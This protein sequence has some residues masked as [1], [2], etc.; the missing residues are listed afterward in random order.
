ML[1]MFT[2]VTALA[3][4]A[5]AAQADVGGTL[6]LY[7]SQPS[8]DAQKTVNAFEAAFPQVKV[9]W[10]R[11][12]TTQMMAKIEAEFAAGDPQPD[13]LLIA[14]MV[15]MERLKEDGRLMA[16]PEAN[17][18]RFDPALMD[19]DHMFFSTKLITTGIVYNTHAKMKPT[20]YTDLL[21][22]EAKGEIAMPSPLNS[23]AAAIQLDAITAN[24]ALGWD[25]YK[26]LADQGAV[27]QG[28][29]G[30]VYK[31]VASGEKL[32]GFVVDYL[33]VRGKAK[34][35]PVAFVAPKEGLT[36]VTEPVAILKTAKNVPAAK[37][38]VSFLLSAK[39]QKLAADMGYI[40]ADPAVAEPAGFPPRDQ[41]KLMAFDPAKALKDNAANLK[42]FADISGG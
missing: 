2:A 18:S 4:S 29:N 32:Y 38:F 42:K 37:A 24:P 27:A 11:G 28:G 5:L 19:P 12:G 26:G 34:G 17:V 6:T 7:T 30:G 41:I 9:R 40:P 13:V 21:K 14:D 31:A 8:A 35:A 36:A 16:D 39:G 20:S 22:P 23:G 3:L 10:V 33:P 25:Y 15:S 1:R